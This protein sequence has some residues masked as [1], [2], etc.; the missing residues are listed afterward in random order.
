YA[1]SASAAAAAYA[2]AAYAAS[3]SAAAYAVAAAKKNINL[4]PVIIEDLKTIRSKGWKNKQG[5]TDLYGEVW[6]RFLSVLDAEGCAYWGRLYKDILDSGFVL[7]R[8]AL[9]RR[10]NIPKE[11]RAC[12]ALKV[13][14]YLEK[15]EEQGTKRL[16]EARIIILGDKGAGKTCLARRLK[17]PK[18]EMTEWHESTAGVDTTFWKL[19]RENINVSIWD[20]AGHTVTHAA[21]KF[22]LSERCLY[23]MVY[24]GRTDDSDKL[25]YWLDHMKNYGGD[26][27][28]I[29][30]VNEFDPHS[31][32]IPV[33]SLKEQYP[34]EGVYTFSIK[35]DKKKLKDFRDKVA[36]YIKSN[37]S[38]ENQV[39]P[40]SYYQV[41]DE[42]E[43]LFVK[44][45]NE[46]GEERITR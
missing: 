19:E 29:I 15:L 11:I 9:K 4:E 46:K 17:D 38:W 22:F 43:T 10:V 44:E 39:I 8:D 20:F 7:D 13:A 42:L 40:A 41:K 33:N 34:I 31:V 16:N 24:N 37:P 12:G 35:K 2:D 3:A 36:D 21:H 23:I 6:D 45:D 27:R 32:E 26:S 25:V 30:L 5:L 14:D 28:A 18:A 1:A